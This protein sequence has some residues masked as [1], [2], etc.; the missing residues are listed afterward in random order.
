[1]KKVELQML[2]ALPLDI[3]IAKTLQR[4]REWV[5]KYG[6]EHCYI[7]F[8]G[9]KDSLVLAHLV[10]SIYPDI[11]LVFSD[12]GLEYPEIRDFVLKQENVVVVKP[13]MTIVQVLE[14]YGYPVVSKQVAGNIYKVR[15]QN[16]CDKFRNY[17]LNGD[18]RGKFAMIPKK[19]QYLL[20]VDFKISNGCCDAMKKRPIKQYEKKSGRFAVFTGET[21]DE[22]RDREKQYLHWGCN[23][24][25]RKSGPKSTPL[26]F[27][28][29]NDILEY[30]H[31]NKLEISSIYG[32]I[33]IKDY[34]KLPN[35]EKCPIYDTT[36]EKRTGC[37][38]CL[39]G[40]HMEKCPHRI[41]RMADTHP[42]IRD[43]VLRGGRYNE[44][45]LWVP[46][47][48]LGFAHI[49]DILKIPFIK[50]EE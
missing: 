47:Q 28:T 25:T 38:F 40:I 30:I 12:T 2:Q 24:F 5:D 10:R 44:D 45:G 39:F 4:I 34:R 26:G 1:M 32:D 17:L 43:Y 49:L 3:K 46:H 29:Y 33:I 27:W 48:G 13:K 7:S 18:E 36:G 8:S 9:G 22:N 37:M 41:D 16:L 50:R 23:A 31:K 15:F 14:K 20:N 11:P 21:A 42:K 6:E 35:G 19:W